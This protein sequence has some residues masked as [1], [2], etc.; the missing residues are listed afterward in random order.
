MKIS[1][2]KKYKHYWLAMVVQGVFYTAVAQ[3]PLQKNISIQATRQ[4]LA[5]VLEIMSNTGNFYFSYNSNIIKKDSLV[6]LNFTNKPVKEILNYLF[7]SNYEFIESGNYIILR[8]KPIS[9]A[10][11]VAKEISTEEK[12][13]YI[14]GYVIDESTGEKLED[15]SVYEPR[16]LSSDLSNEKGYFKVKL[17][18]KYK[19]NTITVSRIFYKDTT[20][21]IQ[22]KFN[23]ELIVYIKPEYYS[24][25]TV[26]IALQ[27]FLIPDSLEIELPTGQKL[28]YTRTDSIKVQKSWMGKF[29]LSSR[30]KIQSVNLKKFFITR[31]FQLSFVPGL[32]T[33]GKLSSQ[34]TNNYSFNVIGG[35][36]GGVNKLELAGVFN[37]TKKNVRSVQAAGV[38]NIVGG[39]VNG[40]QTAGVHNLVYDSVKG[41]QAAGVSN[42]TKGKLNGVQLAGVYNHVSDSING[43]Q[44]AGVANFAKEKIKGWQIAG[45]ANV[46]TKETN[47]VQLAGVFN[48]TKKLKGVQIGLINIADTSDGY[49][50]GLINFVKNGYH[51]LSISSDEVAHLNVAYKSGNRKLYSIIQIGT[52][53][54]SNHKLYSFGYGIGREN[55]LGKQ[56]SITTEL[57]SRYLYL[58]NW[59]YNNLQNKF[60]LN[61]QWKPFKGFSVYAGPSFSLFVSDQNMALPSYQFPVPNAS[62]KKFAIGNKTTGWIGFTAGVNFF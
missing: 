51:Q 39:S 26:T 24:P 57:S 18:S 59:D 33:Q 49:S 13:Y 9:I 42:F 1:F 53:L 8:R 45:V 50:I 29:L 61:F 3:N 23:Q 4:R 47:G 11:T 41:V 31:N 48:Y 54:S 46:S 52:N 7:S 2:K 16:Q 44:A 32:S 12:N 62:Y 35:Y 60:S 15:V 55:K 22:P 43:V 19:A 6:T 36:T 10:P 56:F 17:K 34:V 38:F 20:I 30:Q 5:N 27:D 37:L 25:S 14:T 21:K 40:V 58:G 28:V